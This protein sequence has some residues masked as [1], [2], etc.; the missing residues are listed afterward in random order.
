MSLFGNLFLSV[1]AMKAGTTWLYLVLNRHPELHFTP[2][3]E[4][5]Y[6]YHRYVDNDILSNPRRLQEARNRYLTRFDPKGAD[7]DQVRRNL[8]WVNAYLD[9]P[10]DDLWYRALFQLR[11]RQRYAC[12]FSNLNALLPVE[13][14]P[15]IAAQCS[16]LR[17]L[18]TMR[19]PV[20]RLWSHTKFHLQVSN[21]L[22]SLDKWGP[23]EFRKFLRLP[24]IWKNAE[25]GEVLRNLKAGLPED[26]LKVMFYED[27]HADQLRALR[28]IERFLGISEHPYP[29][30]LMAR[31]PTESV[32][33]EMPAFFPELVAQDIKRIRSEVE[34]EGFRIP[35][36]WT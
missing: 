26:S 15:R 32:K 27:I 5:H 16:N 22:D 29:A 9:S 31:R 30:P 12:D 13:A 3:K 4:I 25:Y 7:I 35:A 24:H 17:V 2:E 10:V 19:D 23:H 21:Q 11:G 28:D 33:R 8:R 1:G 36:S 14:W 34:A 6:F 20:K 18:Y